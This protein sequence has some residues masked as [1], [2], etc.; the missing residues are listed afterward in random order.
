MTHEQDH[1]HWIGWAFDVFALWRRK[2]GFVGVV[3]IGFSYF[4]RN[5]EQVPPWV[6]PTF[7]YTGVAL[8]ILSLV[9]LYPYLK[10]ESNGVP[11]MAEVTEC[12]TRQ[13]KNKGFRGSRTENRAVYRYEID[14]AAHIGRTLWVNQRKFAD[15]KPGDALPILVDPKSPHKAFARQ[16]TPSTS[17]DPDPPSWLT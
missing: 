2:D 1:K 10:I 9:R 16:E 6:I 14:G 8:S 4:L 12:E 17:P 11:I 15:L 13:A 7:L 3:L 5:F